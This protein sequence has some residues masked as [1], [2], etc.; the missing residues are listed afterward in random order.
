M[1][2]KLLLLL[3]FAIGSVSA[4]PIRPNPVLTPGLA[5]PGVTVS[6]LRGNVT[7]GGRTL[8]FAQYSRT[9]HTKDGAVITDAV[10]AK[11]YAEYRI[12]EHKPGDYEVDHLISLELGGSNDLRNL[13]PQA[14]HGT[15]NAHHKDKLENE[16]HRRVLAGRLTLAEAQRLI[17]QDWI[18]LYRLTFPQDLDEHGVPRPT[19]AQPNGEPDR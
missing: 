5:C 9:V 18:A 14:Y 6:D 3:V 17:V 7:A 13:W 16:I 4:Q 8:T 2:T 15:W 19:G 10:K 1:K 12:S 11:V